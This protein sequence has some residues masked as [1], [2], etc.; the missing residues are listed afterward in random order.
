MKKDKK[1]KKHRRQEDFTN[2]GLILCRWQ[3]FLY[4]SEA[5]E[6]TVSIW[7]KLVGGPVMIRAHFQELEV[8]GRFWKH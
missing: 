3:T 1:Q 6:V 5:T 4:I 8:Y 2:M 7:H